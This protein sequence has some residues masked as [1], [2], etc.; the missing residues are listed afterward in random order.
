MQRR[1]QRQKVIEHFDNLEPGDRET[2][3]GRQTLWC[4]DLATWL[5]PSRNYWRICRSRPWPSCCFTEMYRPAPFQ[6]A[7]EGISSL[8]AVE[9][10][11]SLE[12]KGIAQLLFVVLMSEISR[13]CTLFRVRISCM[14]GAMCVVLSCCALLAWALMFSPSTRVWVIVRVRTY[15]PG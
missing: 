7:H 6:R 4:F 1:R 2:P 9:L 5:S 3:T 11:L 8:S 14:S 12:V 15:E 13:R 10:F